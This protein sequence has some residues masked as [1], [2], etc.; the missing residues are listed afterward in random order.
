MRASGVKGKSRTFYPLA[1]MGKIYVIAAGKF[2]FKKVEP[3]M[4]AGLSR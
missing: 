2:G 3:M 1:I 4:Y